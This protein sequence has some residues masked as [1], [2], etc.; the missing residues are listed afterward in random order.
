MRELVLDCETTGLSPHDGHRII[1]LACVEMVNA[2][3]TGAS[4][5]WRFNPERDIPMAASAIH[6]ITIEMLADKPLFAEAAPEILSVIADARLIIHNASFDVGFVNAELTRAGMPPLAADVTCTLMLARRKHPGM[7]NNLDAL[8]QRY[9]I[10]TARRT[11]HGALI[12]CELLAEVYAELTGARQAAL[13]LESASVD[14]RANVV[15]LKRPHSLPSRI[16]AEEA[17][18]HAAFVASLGAK[19]IWLRWAA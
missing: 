9:G 1:E 17:A 18:A 5:L 13:A 10:S 14:D 3:P 7:K 19:A 11:K 16:T 15:A 8:C 6:G 2:I 4:W 12:D